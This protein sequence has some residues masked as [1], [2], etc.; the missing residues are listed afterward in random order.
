MLNDKIIKALEERGFKRWTKNSMDRLYINAETLGLDRE[1]YKYRG[2]RVSNTLAREML[3]AKTYIDIETERVFSGSWTL[4]TDAQAILDEVIETVE[5]EQ[6]QEEP[7]TDSAENSDD[8]SG[9]SDSD[10]MDEKG[11]LNS[12][13]GYGGIFTQIKRAATDEKRAE[14]ESE[15]SCI[16]SRW[17]AVNN[18]IARRG[19]T[20][21]IALGQVNSIETASETIASLE[22]EIA[23]DSVDVERYNEQGKTELAFRAWMEIIEYQAC[24]DAIRMRYTV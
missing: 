19:L 14:L 21:D 1:T 13:T 12:R 20:R 16:K 11:I 5:A 9:M 3:A 7:E 24:I 23:D 6:E 22:E 4:K 10:L 2:E 15:L 8:L 17:V 18:E